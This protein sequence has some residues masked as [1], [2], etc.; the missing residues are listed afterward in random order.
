M[1]AEVCHSGGSIDLGLLLLTVPYLLP[2][3]G[4]KGS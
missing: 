4:K 1:T 2:S 3:I